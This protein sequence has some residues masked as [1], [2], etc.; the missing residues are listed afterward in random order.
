MPEITS[1]D[2]AEYL[3]KF[4][5]LK[6]PLLKKLEEYACSYKIPILEPESAEFLEL[7]LKIYRPESFLEIGTA[8]GYSTIRAAKT[9]PK[10]TYITTIELS[11]HNVEIA[12]SNFQEAG[13]E[14]FINLIEGNALDILRKFDKK[15]DFIFLDADKEDYPDYLPLI[16]KRLNKNGVLLV[17]NLL[18][19]GFVLSQEIPNEYKKSTEF[20]K[21]FNA[22]FLNHPDMKSTIIP[23]GDGLGLGLKIV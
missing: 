16:M 5:S 19:K 4:R 11:N 15:F 17:D 10:C 3:L 14:E 8:I 20:I 1:A 23:I 12:R 22:E 2:L 9:L 13:V 18:W 6:D 7:L 21:K